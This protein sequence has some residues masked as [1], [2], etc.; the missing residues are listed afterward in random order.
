MLKMIIV[1]LATLIPLAP[2]MMYFVG[3]RNNNQ[4]KATQ[5]L[6]FAFKGYN[7]FLAL[8]GLG[9]IVVWLISPEAV[10]AAGV[11]AQEAAADPYASLAAGISTG[12]AALG[13]GV[14]VSGTGAAAIGAIAEKPEALGRS[15]IF[16]GLAEGVAIYG[17][18][19][20]FLVLFG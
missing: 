17:L 16:V 11:A 12:L 13:A 14:A 5:N 18:L 15:L 20:S 8:M 6:V 2:F 4:L 9:I 10:M 19:I 7:V 1:L 3:L